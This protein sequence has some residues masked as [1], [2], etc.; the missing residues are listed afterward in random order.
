MGFF[1]SLSREIARMFAVK[2][3]SP[4]LVLYNFR[5]NISRKS[6][7]YS[8]YGLSNRIISQKRESQRI[9]QLLT[10]LPN[11]RQPPFGIRAASLALH[12]EMLTMTV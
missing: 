2:Y 10:S 8:I 11:L 5:F 3:P 9:I 12:P 1:P 4:L 6:L 7:F